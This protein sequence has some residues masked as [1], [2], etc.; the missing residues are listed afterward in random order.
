[1]YYKNDTPPAGGFLVALKDATGAGHADVRRFGET[2]AD[3]GHGGTGIA[4][5]KGSLYAEI[6]DRI[7][8]YPL[9][10]G[11]IVPG[12]RPET[13]VSGLS[14]TGD[15]P[16]HPFVIDL[17]WRSCR[18]SLQQRCRSAGPGPHLSVIKRI[19]VRHDSTFDTWGTF[20]PGF[21]GTIGDAVVGSCSAYPFFKKKFVQ[22]RQGER[23]GVGDGGYVANN[24][25]LYAIADA[26]E[27]LGFARV[28]VRVVSIGVGEYPSPKLKSG[29]CA[30]GSTSCP[31]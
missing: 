29:A 28:D 13:I 4:L 10:D 5:Y 16:M 21:G 9:R 2:F 17:I 22:T 18:A 8:R 7:V 6:N 26:T 23:V 11:E 24:P 25:A 14:L 31:R 19:P 12:E 20:L 27:L 15:H 3:G 1:M 30:G